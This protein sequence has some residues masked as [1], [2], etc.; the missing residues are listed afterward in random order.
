[1]YFLV[2]SDISNNKYQEILQRLEIEGLAELVNFIGGSNA[3]YTSYNI[4][5]GFQDTIAQ[6][7]THINLKSTSSPIITNL[8]DE[9]K[10]ITVLKTLHP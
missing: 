3:T 6:V 1:M 10:D 4:L 8:V 5:E 9:S 7:I 2:K